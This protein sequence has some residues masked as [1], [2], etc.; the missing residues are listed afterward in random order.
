MTK[1]TLRDVLTPPEDIGILRWQA[2]VPLATNPFL[3]LELVQ[4]ALVG[5]SIVL[6][7]LCLGVWITDGVL[8][9]EDV[10]TSLRAAAFVALA[11]L[12][13]FLLVSLV[14]FDNRYF[15][16]YQLDS[17]G[18]YHESS[19]GTDEKRVMLYLKTRPGP[20]AGSVK[21]GRTR[22]RH[23]P[24]EKTDRFQPIP[25]M[26]VIVLRRGIWHMMR[27]YLPDD[28]TFAKA[29]EFLAGRLKKA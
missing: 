6:V 3:L 9:V 24:W 26:R 21:A 27:L 1:K 28:A 16:V 4:L 19:R 29:E 8:L 23:L 13:A 14:F 18:I 10:Y 11:I 12:A 22:S 20:V 5:A 15:A 25:A 17:G 7:T 2:T